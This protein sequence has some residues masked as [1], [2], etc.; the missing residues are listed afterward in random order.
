MEIKKLLDVLHV[1]IEFDSDKRIS[2]AVKLINDVQQIAYQD[3][4]VLNACFER[5]PLY[6]GDIPSKSGR[7][8]LLEA[9]YISKIIVNGEEGFNACTYKGAQAYRLIKAIN[10][11]P[12]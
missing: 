4:D 10:N 3:I 11:K 5:G 2:N 6:D 8:N 12:Q 1:G 7:D 9:G